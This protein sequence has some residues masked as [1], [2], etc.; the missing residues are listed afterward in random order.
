MNLTPLEVHEL[1]RPAEMPASMLK[2]KIED[3]VYSCCTFREGRLLT[4]QIMG[5]NYVISLFIIHAEKEMKLELKCSGPGCSLLFLARGRLRGLMS[6]R[7]AFS[8]E[9]GNARLVYFNHGS[10]LIEVEAGKV[11]C[12]L[13]S[14]SGGLLS[15]FA[16]ASPVAGDLSE[17]L[18]AG[19]AVSAVYR[20]VAMSSWVNSNLDSL[21]D[22]D[23]MNLLDRIFSELGIIN[24]MLRRYLNQLRTEEAPDAGDLRM[25][26]LRYFIMEN[27]TDALPVKS[28]A[29]KHNMSPAALQRNFRL[30]YGMGVHDFMLKERVRKAQEIMNSQEEVSLSSVAAQCGFYDLAHFTKTFKKIVGI[31]PSLYKTTSS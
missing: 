17:M 1:N 13:I 11:V 19:A 21:F 30:L 2:Y 6:D 26:K 27:A 20:P 22:R 29:K 18:K 16:E 24:D 3:A 23:K 4:Q 14:Y 31:T 5:Y 28:L 7:S 15:Q 25:E 8:L 9:A 10:H 12:W